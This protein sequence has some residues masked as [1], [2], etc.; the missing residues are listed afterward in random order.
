MWAHLTLPW[1]RDSLQKTTLVFS[2]KY[3][4]IGSLQACMHSPTTHAKINASYDPPS[5]E[6]P[7]YDQECNQP[8]EYG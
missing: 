3:Q 7:P 4:V 1:R 6:I 8:C 5:H 2:G